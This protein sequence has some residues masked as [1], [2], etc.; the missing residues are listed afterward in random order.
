MSEAIT[1]LRK[2]CNEQITR[3]N[4]GAGVNTPGFAEINSL[5]K[6]CDKV[7]AEQDAKA[8]GSGLHEMNREMTEQPTSLQGLVAAARSMRPYDNDFAIS[9]EVYGDEPWTWE[10]H[11]GSRN[12]SVSILETGGRLSGKGATPEDA[13]RNLIGVIGRDRRQ[14]CDHQWAEAVDENGDLVEPAMDIC[15]QCGERRA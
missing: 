9:L 2:L 7:F 15:V 11:M 10:A 4:Q 6:A 5:L 14:T 8:A 12:T 13:V 1:A 3:I